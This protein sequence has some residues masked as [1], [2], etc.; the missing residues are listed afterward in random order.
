MAH[1]PC[2]QSVGA[3]IKNSKGEYL[4]LY[5]KLKPIGLGLPAGHVEFGET[6]E[7]AFLRETHEEVGI[8]PKKYRIVLRGVIPGVCRRGAKKHYWTVFRVEKYFG[9]PHRKEKSK[10]ANVKFKSVKEI[11]EYLDS[12]DVDP[13]WVEIFNRLNIIKR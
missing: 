5:R 13:A 12:N 9:K 10:H 6:P 4:T 3:I 11:R 7:E 1:K 8:R 2:C